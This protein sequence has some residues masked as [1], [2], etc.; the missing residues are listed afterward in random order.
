MTSTVKHVTRKPL[1]AVA[2][3]AAEQ[4]ARNAQLRTQFPPRAVEEWWLHIAASLEQV[5]QRL[6]AA[7]PFLAAASGTRDVTTFDCH[8]AGGVS[9]A[10]RWVRDRQR[11]ASAVA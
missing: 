6:A 9:C 3:V 2:A 1:P 11:R 4:R 8:S 5:Q 7:P 10:G